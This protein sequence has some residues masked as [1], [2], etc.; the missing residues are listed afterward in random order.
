MAKAL[1]KGL[2][3]RRFGASQLNALDTNANVEN[4]SIFIKAQNPLG[5]FLKKLKHSKSEHVQ[6]LKI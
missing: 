3:K 6:S 1:K 2:P 5:L 4:F